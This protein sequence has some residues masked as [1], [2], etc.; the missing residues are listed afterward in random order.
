MNGLLG[1]NK[2]FDEERSRWIIELEG[3][4]EKAIKNDNILQTLEPGATLLLERGCVAHVTVGRD[5]RLDE[6]ESDVRESLDE[7]IAA[8]A[9]QTG[10]RAELNRVEGWPQFS[11]VM[12]GHPHEVQ[13]A[14]I[15]VE[16]L[17][18]HYGMGFRCLGNGVGRHGP[19]ERTDGNEEEPPEVVE[20]EGLTI[21]SK[22][23]RARAKPKN[24]YGL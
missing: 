18:D 2:G 24:R 15:E 21:E 16:K 7:D 23:R 19:V 10:V 5:A 1:L 6:M 9:E 11:I 13:N 14:L 17:F 12:R 20:V 3:G 8:F 4:E 22:G